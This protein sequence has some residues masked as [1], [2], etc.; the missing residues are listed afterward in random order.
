MIRSKGNFAASFHQVSIIYFKNIKTD[1]TNTERIIIRLTDLGM[2]PKC[3][4]NR[5]GIYFWV[6]QKLPGLADFK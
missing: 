5:I 3:F 1:Y 6:F 2:G 4:G